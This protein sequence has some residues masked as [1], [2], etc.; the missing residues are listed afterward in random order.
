MYQTGAVMSADISPDGEWLVTSGDDGR[1]HLWNFRTGE[2]LSP[3]YR[4]GGPM[5]SVRFSPDG[6]TFAM[7]G[8]GVSRSRR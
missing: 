6:T 3:V 2:R 8:S 5:Y 4:P 1:A 7:G